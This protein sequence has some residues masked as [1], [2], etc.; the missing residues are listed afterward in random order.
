MSQD[1]NTTKK[2]GRKIKN[3]IILVSV[4]MGVILLAILGILI[5]RKDGTKVKVTIDGKLFGEYSLDKDQTVEIKSDKG[6]NLLVIKDGKAYVESASCPDG[7]CSS[8]KPISYGGE[9]IICL[10][11][12][13][14][15]EVKAKDTNEQ[16]AQ[17][18][19][20]S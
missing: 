4:L 9:S 19:I 10:P 8:H 17:P 14:V 7:I 15:I 11:N 20:I 5:F 2:N 1:I 3:D 13:V 16:K 6:K 12:K 18:D